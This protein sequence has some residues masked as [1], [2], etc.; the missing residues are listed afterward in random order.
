MKACSSS[1]T[2]F[3]CLARNVYNDAIGMT[4]AG[5]IKKAGRDPPNAGLRGEF[6][7]QLFALQLDLTVDAI[8][9]R[10][11]R[12]LNWPRRV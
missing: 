6:C 5:D 11:L 4:G 8:R 2:D 7:E 3:G 12:F 9:R 10:R 1:G